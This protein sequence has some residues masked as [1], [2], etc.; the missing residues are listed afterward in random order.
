MK[1]L[2][3]IGIFAFLSLTVFCCCIMSS[4]ADREM[5]VIWKNH[6]EK[7][8][9]EKEEMENEKENEPELDNVFN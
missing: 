3:A 6:E 7:K 2:F 8:K 5:A 9:K 4:R 1:I